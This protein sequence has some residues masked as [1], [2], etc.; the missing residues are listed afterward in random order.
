MACAV[1]VSALIAGCD[2]AGS[3]GTGD[4]AA[5]ASPVI[6]MVT[7]TASAEFGAVDVLHLDPRLLRD[8][9]RDPP[10]DSVW[11]RIFVLHTGDAPP[12]NSSVP[13]VLGSWSVQRD[14][15]RFTPQFPPVPGQTYVARFD[16]VMLRSLA[17]GSA[18]GKSTAAREVDTHRRTQASPVDSGIADDRNAAV[19]EATLLVPRA[20]H[21]TTTFVA[22]IHPSADHVPVNLLRMYVHFSS[23]MS[24]GEAY[25]RITLRD[26]EGGIVEDAFLVVQQE[27]WDPERRRLTLLFDPGRIKRDLR[28]HEEAGMPLRQGQTYTLHIDSA[29]LDAAGRPLGA[30]RTKTFSAGPADRTSPRTRDWRLGSAAAGTRA[31]ITLAFPE[32]LD[33]ALLER[34]LTVMHAD[35]RSV[36]GR[37][38]V[39]RSGRSWEFTPDQ[40]WPTGDYA[41]EVGTDIEDLAGNN[42]RHLFD[43]D[44]SEAGSRTGVANPTASIV[45]LPFR[46]R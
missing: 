31:P 37:G 1:C 15:L 25:R 9:A 17:R 6:A 33:H 20:A 4:G 34:L 39:I 14:R 7:D 22:D 19:I 11:P 41:V 13:P 42:L 16:G 28:P 43:V 5:G 35:G 29:W 27:L 45:S 2:T 40:P 23:P 12:A 44:R 38:V 30:T 36:A 32:P 24:T 10:A 46:I 18:D 26:G 3:A 21:G 8:L